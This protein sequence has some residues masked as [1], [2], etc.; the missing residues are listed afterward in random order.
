[1]TF[2]DR[3]KQLRKE[4]GW[5]QVEFAEHVG[6]HDRH[7]SRWEK[8]T[9]RPTGRALTRIAEVLG[10]TPE[11]LLAGKPEARLQ[12][13]LPDPTL[14]EQFQQI[15]SLPAEERAAIHMVIDAFLTKRRMEDVLR[16]L[17]RS[18]AS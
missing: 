12:E 1:M 9:N 13:V 17:T 6:V 15:Q 14:L 10:V 3:V 5:T 8:D 7:I 11:E 16:P 2:G 4:R 18:R